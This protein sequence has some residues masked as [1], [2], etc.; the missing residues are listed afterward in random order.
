[1]NR[2]IY[3]I[4]E[5][6]T[7][8][9]AHYFKDFERNGIAFLDE[10]DGKIRPI[11]Y[12]GYGDSIDLAFNDNVGLSVYHRV[13]SVTDE[14]D[15]EAG[16]GR[17]SLKTETYSMIM[18]A[19]GNQRAIDDEKDINY[20]IADELQSL[21][22][23]RLT[24]VQLT[25]IEAKRGIVKITGRDFDK[26]NIFNTEM[27][28]N[29]YKIHPE[30]IL[31][32]INYDITI[33]FDESC[34]TLSC[35]L[36]TPLIDLKAISCD[37]INH[38]KFGL[39]DKQLNDCGRNV[40]SSCATGSVKNSD[41]SYNVTVASGGSLILPDI[42]H[43]D[44]DGSNVIKPAQTPFVA[45]QK[46]GIRYNRPSLTGE[47]TDYGA[48]SDGARQQAGGYDFSSDP[49]DPA[50][51]AML[52]PSDRL[53]L[54]DNNEFENTDRFTNDK[55][56]SVYDGSDGS[57]NEYGI[58]NFTG[59]GWHVVLK[60][61]IWAVALADNVLGIYDDMFLPN[62]KEME[63]LMRYDSE[64]FQYSP[65]NITS[66]A[67]FFSSTTL[68]SSTTRAVDFL[69]ENRNIGSFIKANASNYFRTRKHF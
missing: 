40:A 57:T 48:R 46:S 14:E 58:D 4:D 28:D 44:S 6:N 10:K 64:W 45:T 38:T 33:I 67:R 39:T 2:I 21:F 1:M 27:P 47:T 29:E 32:Q 63:E 54:V 69:P 49:D 55:G 60:N 42:T 59:Y 19:F 37:N 22:P 12:K 24:S 8:L 68:D 34:K 13:I 43:V 36:V 16:F 23:N 52:D 50:I 3:I 15:D 62:A 5:I 56:G 66:N 51:I 7:A 17:N 20:K 9:K 18:V 25:N 61:A 26:R 11:H 35:D 30:H 41:S 31:F 65:F 53:L